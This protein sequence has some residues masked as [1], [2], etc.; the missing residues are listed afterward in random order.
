MNVLKSPILE[1]RYFSHANICKIY[2]S[3]DRIYHSG[4][5]IDFGFYANFSHKNPYLTSQFPFRHPVKKNSPRSSL[6]S[7]QVIRASASHY[8]KSRRMKNATI[9]PSSAQFN[10]KGG[11]SSHKLSNPGENRIAFKIKCSN[12]DHYRMNP[13]YGFVEPGA[14]ANIDIHRLVRP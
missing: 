11:V 10:A 2:R 5:N 14:T 8:Q 6:K 13:V 12:N 3:T 1:A 9:E 4:A 7:P